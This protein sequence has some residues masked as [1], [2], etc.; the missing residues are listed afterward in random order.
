MYGFLTLPR[1]LTKARTLVDEPSLIRHDDTQFGLQKLGLPMITLV[2]EHCGSSCGQI[3]LD[4]D[5]VEIIET[6]AQIETDSQTQQGSGVEDLDLFPIC[7]GRVGSMLKQPSLDSQGWDWGEQ[8][9]QQQEPSEATS[10]QGL[11]LEGAR[12]SQLQLV[13]ASGPGKQNRAGGS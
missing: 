3:V 9:T 2:A 6:Q 7:D 11:L 13:S 1:C 8:E 10:S 12:E 4:D 5:D